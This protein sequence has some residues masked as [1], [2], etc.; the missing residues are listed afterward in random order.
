MEVKLMWIKN[1]SDRTY[2]SMELRDFKP[3][4]KLNLGGKLCTYLLKTFPKWFKPCSGVK[5]EIVEKV[6]NF[7]TKPK[8]KTASEK[9][10]ELDLELKPKTVSG[11]K[12]KKTNTEEVKK[13]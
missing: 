6:T 12:V 9:T 8:V 7:V 11:E 5:E 2:N 10:S 4:T 1:V 3:G 13:K